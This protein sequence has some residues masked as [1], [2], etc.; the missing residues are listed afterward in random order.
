MSIN[1]SYFSNTVVFDLFG[2]AE[3]QGCIPLD[4]GTPVHMSAQES[5]NIVSILAFVAITSGGG[6][7]VCWR[8]PR[9]PGSPS[10]RPS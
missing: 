8:R 2:G 5:Q 10:S 4:R 7:G 9:V 3:V 6:P 1:F